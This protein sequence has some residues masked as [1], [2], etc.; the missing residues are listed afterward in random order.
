MSKKRPPVGLPL[1]VRAS[2]IPSAQSDIIEWQYAVFMTDPDG[3]VTIAEGRESDLETFRSRHNQQRNDDRRAT[4]SDQI[5]HHSENI[6]K[7]AEVSGEQRCIDQ[8]AKKALRDGL[9]RVLSTFEKTDPARSVLTHILA[10]GTDWDKT[11][12]IAAKLELDVQQVT[13]AKRKIQRR[14]RNNFPALRKHLGR[15]SGF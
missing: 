9:K 2:K 15:A 6:L 8:E 5:R 13:V 11:Q 1:S 7:H 4:K 3:N 10:V 14:V 12:E